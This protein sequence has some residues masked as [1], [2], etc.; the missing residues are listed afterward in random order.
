MGLIAMSL[1]LEEHLFN[2]HGGCFA[3][4]PLLQIGSWIGHQYF[5]DVMRLL[6]DSGADPSWVG[7]DGISIDRPTIETWCSMPEEG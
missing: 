7:P 4:Y 6:L 2:S 3:H 5:Q 1:A